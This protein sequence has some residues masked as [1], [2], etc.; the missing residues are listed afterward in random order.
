M[1]FKDIINNLESRSGKKKSY[2]FNRMK[3]LLLKL[4]N[5]QK[6]LKYFHIAGTNGKGST[7]N[8]I[9]NILKAKGYKTGLYTS[10]HLVKYNERIII[11]D[12][13]IS[14]DDFE[15]SV[16][17]RIVSEFV[18]CLHLVFHFPY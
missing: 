17:I 13:M 3:S 8:F 12:E 14:D 7:S 16:P 18:Q 2:D 1:E 6:N 10:P 9:Y 11:N 5:P 4:E 15:P